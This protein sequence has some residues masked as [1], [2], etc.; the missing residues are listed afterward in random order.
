MTG[1]MAEQGE[2][3]RALFIR[4]RWANDKALKQRAAEMGYAPAQ[5]DWAHDCPV[6]AEQ[7]LWAEKAVA[8][9]D[10]HGIV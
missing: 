5:A 1:A 4:S 7:V 10:R 8:H 9:G 2:D 6:A 3:P